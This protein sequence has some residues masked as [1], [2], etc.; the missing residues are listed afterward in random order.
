MKDKKSKSTN[1][2]TDESKKISRIFWIRL[3]FCKI[4]VDDGFIEADRRDGLP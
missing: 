2:F 3:I 4:L 1:I